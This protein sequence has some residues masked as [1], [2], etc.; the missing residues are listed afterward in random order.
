MQS[1][2]SLLVIVPPIHHSRDRVATLVSTNSSCTVCFSACL[3]VSV[4]VCNQARGVAKGLYCLLPRLRSS[5][6]APRETQISQFVWVFKF[7]RHHSCQLIFMES[8]RRPRCESEQRHGE[9]DSANGH[10]DKWKNVD[11]W[12]SHRRWK[13]MKERVHHL[14]RSP[15][16]RGHKQYLSAFA[17]LNYSLHTLNTMLLLF[18]LAA[19]FCRGRHN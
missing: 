6:F 17:L 13:R 10:K 12:E 19:P 3:S 7:L 11:A 9:A 18:L 4:H 14:D 16:T 8:Q 15:T 2:S 1:Q 5:M